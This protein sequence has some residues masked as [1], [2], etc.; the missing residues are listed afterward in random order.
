MQASLSAYEDAPWL[1]GKVGN[2]NLDRLENPC[3]LAQLI[4]AEQL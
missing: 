3:D 1:T 4:D 2:I